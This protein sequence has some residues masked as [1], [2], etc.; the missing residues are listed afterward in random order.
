MQTKCSAEGVRGVINDLYVYVKDVDSL[1]CCGALVHFGIELT[2]SHR[3]AVLF[4]DAR[5]AVETQG[6]LQRFRL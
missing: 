1:A 3:L 5:P 4:Q 6:P 2:H